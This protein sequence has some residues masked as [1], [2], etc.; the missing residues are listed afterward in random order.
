MKSLMGSLASN[1]FLIARRIT[2]VSIFGLF[3]IS[4]VFGIWVIKG[5]LNSSVLLGTIPLTDPFIL[6]QS[7]FA[8][9]IPELTAITGAF[10]LAAFYF[11][12]GGRVFCSWVCPL[13]I[14]TDTAFWLRRKLNLRSGWSP[15][16]HIRFWLLGTILIISLITG[17]LAWENINPVTMTHRGIINGIGLAWIFIAIIFVFDLFIAPRGWCG[18]L[19]PTGAF[20]ALLGHFSPLKITAANRSNCDDCGE[21]YR[22]CPEP[23]V[24]KPA[25]KG[26]SK[27][28]TANVCNNCGRCIDVCPPNVFRYSLIITSRTKSKLQQVDTMETER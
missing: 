15:S 8:Q 7:V 2:Q 27:I 5:N 23:R 10:F 24:L 26:P 25:L 22:I 9:H 3:L 11:L 18:H 20:Y 16:S 17:S 6:I 1:R 19:C 14:V 21:C 4:P 12:L 28:I 13:N